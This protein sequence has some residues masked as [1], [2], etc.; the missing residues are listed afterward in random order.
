MCMTLYTFQCG[1][2]GCLGME[3]NV[4]EVETAEAPPQRALDPGDAQCVGWL[5]TMA[6][7]ELFDLCMSLMFRE[8]IDQHAFRS[9]LA[10]FEAAR[11]T[12]QCQYMLAAGADAEPCSVPP[13]VVDCAKRFAREEGARRLPAAVSAI[14]TAAFTLLSP[15]LERAAAL[16]DEWTT[17]IYSAGEAH[18]MLGVIQ[19]F[20]LLCVWGPKT[21]LAGVH[22]RRSIGRTKIRKR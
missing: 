8:D 22:R 20:L 4:P 10:R 1:G 6:R 21:T 5:S 2:R 18:L 7:A 13:H 11:V 14:R 17:C 15:E 9:H 12:H 16:I 3:T 19:S